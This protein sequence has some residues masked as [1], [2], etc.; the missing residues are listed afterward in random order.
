MCGKGIKT[1]E[2]TMELVEELKETIQVKYLSTLARYR[3]EATVPSSWQGFWVST[4]NI[5]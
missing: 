2:Y 3:V 5:M 1:P 4:E